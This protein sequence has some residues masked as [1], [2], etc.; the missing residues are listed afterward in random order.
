MLTFWTCLIFVLFLDIYDCFKIKNF[1]YPNT[2]PVYRNCSIKKC[3][4]LHK[5]YYNSRTYQIKKNVQEPNEQTNKFDDTYIYHTPVLL[6]EVIY[7]MMKDEENSSVSSFDQNMN[8][9]RDTK[10]YSNNINSI[11][12]NIN[13]INCSNSS[14]SQGYILEKTWCHLNNNMNRS[15]RSI[16]NCSF[17]NEKKD[18]EYIEECSENFNSKNTNNLCKNSYTTN[19]NNEQVNYYIDATLG[20]GGH[21]LEILNKIPN[22]R[23]IGI[24]KDIEALY[25]NKIKLKRFINNNK[26]KLIHGDYGN[27]L[28]LLH[29]H[30]LPIFN[31]YSGILIDLGVSSHQLKC[32]DRGFSYKYNGIL[33]MNMNKYTESQYLSKLFRNDNE[34]INDIND[35]KKKP[36]KI[37]I[38]NFIIF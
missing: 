35:I 18:I 11:N 10:C 9:N 14:K 7:Y 2:H 13:S 4:S 16:K 29:L 31:Y 6:R 32:C 26:L 22:C 1:E 34:H 37:V 38:I 19:Y 5:G 21:T 24:D 3:N 33:D 27:I 20:G 17:L 30:S 25:Y 15:S 12:N 8:D 28:H 36:K 23:I